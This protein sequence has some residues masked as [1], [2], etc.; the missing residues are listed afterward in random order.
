[1]L[2]LKEFNEYIPDRTAP[3]HMQDGYGATW[4]QP[5]S[6]SI[7]FDLDPQTGAISNFVFSF[8]SSGPTDHDITMA[9]KGSFVCG[10][11]Q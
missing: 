6:A 9:G 2:A 7:A 1:M 4:D 3:F 5:A 8:Q 10:T 11:G